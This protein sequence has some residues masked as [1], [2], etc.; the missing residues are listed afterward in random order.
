MFNTVPSHPQPLSANQF[1]DLLDDG[2][3]AAAD[4]LDGRGLLAHSRQAL[5]ERML[6]RKRPY[7][8]IKV[9]QWLLGLTGEKVQ[10]TPQLRSALEGVL[11]YYR[12][13]WSRSACAVPGVA[14]WLTK[15]V[16]AVTGAQAGGAVACGSLATE[17]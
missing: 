7:L 13:S 11:R 12:P 3:W 17:L 4:W 15:L 8:P 16:E 1:S 2:N 5:L 6:L 9:L 10:W 14:R